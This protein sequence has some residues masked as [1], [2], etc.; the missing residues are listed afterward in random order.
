MSNSSRAEPRVLNDSAHGPGPQ[1]DLHHLDASSNGTGAAAL[2]R[3]M[4]QSSSVDRAAAIALQD[5]PSARPSIKTYT[6]A[7]SRKRHERSTSAERDS[8]AQG[9]GTKKRPRQSA[10]LK[11]VKAPCTSLSFVFKHATRSLV[12][13]SRPYLNFP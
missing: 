5:G 4:A 6:S 13:L 12:E 3:E 1:P 10:R 7:A 9:E 11:G 8:A 2:G